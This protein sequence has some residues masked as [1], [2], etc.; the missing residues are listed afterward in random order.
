MYR[1]SRYVYWNRLI[2]IAL[3]FFLVAFTTLL[4]G[5][6]NFDSIIGVETCSAWFWILAFLSAPFM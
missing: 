5:S 2:P 4:K 6:K 3:A 1:E